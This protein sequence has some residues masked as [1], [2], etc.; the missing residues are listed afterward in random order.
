MIEN[1][2]MWRKKGMAGTASNLLVA[3]LLIRT[4]LSKTHLADWGTF[5]VGDTA[6]I[7]TKA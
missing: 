4:E 2:A 3:E 7:W 1:I 5:L 6:S